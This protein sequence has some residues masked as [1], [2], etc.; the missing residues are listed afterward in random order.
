MAAIA[1]ERVARFPNVR[2]VV[3][4]FEHHPLPEAGF[5]AAVSASAWHWIDPQV[6]FPKIARAEGRRRIGI[7]WKLA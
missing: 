2:I 5:D 7:A 6:G 1:R 3:A 4:D